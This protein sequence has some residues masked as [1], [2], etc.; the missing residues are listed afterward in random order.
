M[1]K[2]ARQTIS[3][4][5]QHP[6]SKDLIFSKLGLVSADT[7]KVAPEELW[8]HD[9][10]HFGGTM[11][12][13][14]LANAAHI[15]KGA[16]VVDFCAGLGGTARYLAYQYGCSVTGIELTPTRVEARKNSVSLSDFKRLP[17]CFREM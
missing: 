13:D 11:A 3:F 12:T 2:A 17:A 6:I 1:N 8:P 5:S 7:R 9:Q 16:R 4:Y 10:D 15:C 14:K